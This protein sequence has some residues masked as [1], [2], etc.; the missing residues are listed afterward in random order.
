MTGTH[1]NS[2]H[3][4]HGK[5]SAAAGVPLSTSGAT[6]QSLPSVS[7]SAVSDLEFAKG[8][9]QSTSSLAV[10]S[11]CSHSETVYTKEVY[12]EEQTLQLLERIESLHCDMI[13]RRLTMAEEAKMELLRNSIQ[14]C[15]RIFGYSLF[16][17]GIGK[18][19]GEELELKFAGICHDARMSTYTAE[20]KAKDGTSHKA[21]SKWLDSLY[22]IEKSLVHPFNHI[23]FAPRYS[24]PIYKPTPKLNS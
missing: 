12:T 23:K 14:A 11:V 13:S 17:E 8:N 16:D 5:Y 4:E 22:G 2:P 9:I 20:K 21:A 15:G 19:N 24:R 1:P 10:D 6:S 7:P 18:E 3:V